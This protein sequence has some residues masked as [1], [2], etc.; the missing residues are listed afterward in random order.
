MS[1]VLF[2]NR[3]FEIEPATVDDVVGIGEAHLKSWLETYP[4]ASY[5]VTE[6]WIKSELGFLVEDGQREDGRDNGIPYRRRLIE[7]NDPNTIYEVVKDEDG[8]VQG[9]LHAR[10]HQ[11]SATLDAI[12]LMN[13]LKGTG[14]AAELMAHAL[15]FIGDLPVRLQAVAYNERAIHFYEKYGFKRGELEPEFYH[16]RMP[17]INMERSA[18]GQI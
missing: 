9:F 17:V 1:E 3:K 8:V 11:G 16:G 15:E 10:R 5:D 13:S 7:M 12:Y 4:N 6:E 2:E 18:E 14:V